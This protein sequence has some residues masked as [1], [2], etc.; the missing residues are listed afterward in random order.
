[1]TPEQIRPLYEQQKRYTDSAQGAAAEGSI[2]I[3]YGRTA[4][5]AHEVGEDAV[6]AEY[7]AKLPAMTDMPTL[8]EFTRAYAAAPHQFMHFSD[9]K[10]FSAGGTALSNALGSY[11]FA[12]DYLQNGAAALRNGGEP[13]WVCKWG[14]YALRCAG[15]EQ[16]AKIV[17]QAW[18]APQPG[19]GH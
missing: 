5:L 13:E 10:N 4:G 8:A 12:L 9:S 19:I 2:A 16:R 15:F 3:A 18:Q 1:M 14:A 17:E 11:A 7:W 6:A